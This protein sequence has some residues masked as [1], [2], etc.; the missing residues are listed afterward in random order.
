MLTKVHHCMVDGVA[1][2]DLMS[3]MFSDV[4]GSAAAADW[5]PAPVPSGIEILVRT[6]ARRAVS[7]RAQLGAVHEA[8]SAPR[9]ALR[10]GLE[11]AG[12]IAKSAGALRPLR[13]SSLTGPIGPH[14]VWR[15]GSVRLSD[16][17]AV[18]AALGGTVND[19]VLTVITN[20]FRE[21]LES[22]GEAVPADRT[23][24]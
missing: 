1:A 16:V 14:R 5:A 9:E 4:A 19:V 22:R 17:K 11:I 12:A 6:L 10:A 2:T 18:R 23:V 8:L 3:S 21:L 13:A 15:W 7:P 20:G 24:R